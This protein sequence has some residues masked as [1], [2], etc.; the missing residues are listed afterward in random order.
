[1]DATKSRPGL[2][3]ALVTIVL[4][5]V[6]VA[7]VGGRDVGI[8]RADGP[9]IFMPV[10]VRHF[11]G[12][13]APAETAGPG[14]PTAA[15][16]TVPT[17]RPT[18]GPTDVPADTPTPPPTATDG[19][20][21]TPTLAGTAIEY[22]ADPKQI[23]LQVGVTDTDEVS[24]VWEEMNG[25]PWFTVYGDGRVI[26]GKVLDPRANL[27]Q[28]LFEGRVSEYTLQVWLRAL[29]N[30]IG[31]YGLKDDYQHSRGSKP[32]VHFWLQTAQ[33]PSGK[34]VS[35]RG[36]LMMERR[37]TEEFGAAAD[38]IAA[39]VRFGRAL[40]AAA[41]GGGDANL[42]DPFQPV[43][44]T[45]LAQKHNVEYVQG[46]PRWEG[47]VNV[48][49]VAMAA[50]TAASNYVDRVV[51]HYFADGTVGREMQS[52]IVPVAR[53]WFPLYR[54][55]AEF[56]VSG[57]PHGVGARQEVPGGS[58]FLPQMPNPGGWAGGVDIRRTYWYRHDTGPRCDSLF[59][60]P[61]ADARPDPAV[62]QVL[63]A[64]RAAR[65]RAVSGFQRL[66]DLLPMAAAPPPGP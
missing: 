40:E 19:P 62:L 32:E 63:E 55:A 49:A 42:G 12:P 7:T 57:R 37:G 52:L 58:W 61:L 44:Y 20:T 25:T 30:D 46:A 33:Y 50:P 64:L 11:D 21:P 48:G 14:A 41:Q 17:A 66:S 28:E 31:F 47:K 2:F 18:E 8:A 29:V 6:A 60:R 3:L 4:S 54:R 35:L 38:R 27:D 1:M 39:L 22:N 34:R 16:T 24:A 23:V 26:A 15:A 9:P 5:A 59:Q 36:Y 10:S 56:T 13:F 45:I 51:G 65:G 53:Q 43:C